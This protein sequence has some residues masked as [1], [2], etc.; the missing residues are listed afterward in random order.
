VQLGLKVVDV[1]LGGGQLVLTMLQPGASVIEEVGL[2][3]TST[4]S[5]HQLVVHL[6][7]TRLKVGVLL[8]KLLVTLLNVLDGAV[9]SLHLVGILL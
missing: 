4:I 9:L 8:K 7:D 3:V 1:A 5:P 6:L 2:E